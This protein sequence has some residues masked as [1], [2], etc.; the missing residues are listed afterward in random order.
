MAH[1]S[2]DAQ[3]KEERG[4]FG[5]LSEDEDRSLGIYFKGFN[6]YGDKFPEHQRKPK[7]V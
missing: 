7:G 5:S 3:L 2:E 4:T 6:P 1:A